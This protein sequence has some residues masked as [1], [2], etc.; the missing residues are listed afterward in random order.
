MPALRLL[1]LVMMLLPG[2]LSAQERIV[3]APTLR[4]MASGTEREIAANILT[5]D[6]ERNR[7]PSVL[8]L[9]SA[10]AT[11]AASYCDGTG[12]L[13]AAPIDASALAAASPIASLDPAA[14]LLVVLDAPGSNRDPTLRE[15][16]A[17]DVVDGAVRRTLVLT[18]TA[19]TSGVFAGVVPAAA[20][21][22]ALACAPVIGRHDTPT[23]SFAGDIGSL[24]STL[25]PQLDPGNLVFDATGGALVDGA[26]VTL[27]TEA[28]AP[29]AVLGEDGVSGYPATVT[30]GAAVVDAGAHHYPAVTGRFRFPLVA[31]GCY[32]LRIEPPAG[33]TAPSKASAEAL[34]ALRD[35]AGEPF[36]LNAGSNGGVVTLTAPGPFVTDTPLDPTATP[37]LVLTRSLSERDA[38]PGD[39]IEARLQLTNRGTGASGVIHLG[40]VLP[41]G[42][43][44]RPGSMRG[45]PEP[46][47]AAAGRSLD[48]VLPSLAPGASTEIR[49]I[50]T[51]P[52]G[53]A[54]GEASVRAQARAA[55]ATSNVA[56]AAVR[57]RALLFTDALT[58]VG[59]V[60]EGDC[61]ARPRGVA[62]V[63]L[64][65]EDG[66]VVV[67][68]PAGLYHLEGHRRRPPRPRTRRRQPAAGA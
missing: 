64:L 13:V 55:L 9:R 20:D 44:Y 7:L 50:L 33:Y 32:R 41:A 30:S 22:A 35:A 29:A 61:T 38:S 58:L 67:T 43:R 2:A 42:L 1:A 18:E 63:R 47:V 8:S 11:V 14:S 5:L 27:L 19:V 57:I 17:V 4:Y 60:G 12:R 24:P 62:G 28:G 10:P 66:T 31:A 53:A 15:M 26:S 23:L 39:R 40:D 65:L 45:A 48:T 49:F 68:D 3:N 51:V 56:A 37:T 16:V 36:V 52:P 59:Q 21:R 6:V 54:Q 25:T 46:T 34:A